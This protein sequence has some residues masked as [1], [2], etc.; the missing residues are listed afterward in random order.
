M[1]SASCSVDRSYIPLLCMSRQYGQM[2]A[3]ETADATA[4][5][6]SRSAVPVSTNGS[7]T[8]IQ[9]AARTSGAGECSSIGG[10]TILVSSAPWAYTSATSPPA[11]ATGTGR[12]YFT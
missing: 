5:L 12:R 3:T 8:S 9:Y 1:A 11:E 10:V 7:R 6:L 2:L 4:S